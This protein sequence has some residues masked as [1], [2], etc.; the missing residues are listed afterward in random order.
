[1][2]VEL[3]YKFNGP[4]QF[5]MD[6]VSFM[7]VAKNPEHHGQIKHLDLWFYWLRD[8]VGRGTIELMYMK[9]EDMPIM[10]WSISNLFFLSN[11]L[12][13]IL[14]HFL[15]LSSHMTP[16]LCS[17]APQHTIS[18]PTHGLCMSFILTLSTCGPSH[19]LHMFF[20]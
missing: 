14:S 4:S 5:W 11:L 2:L 7:S 1:M 16:Q 12:S 20:F 19:A 10:E 17:T 8:E 6:N 13:T 18:Q 15:I 9:T 3:D